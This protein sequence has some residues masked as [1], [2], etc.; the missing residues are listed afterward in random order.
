MVNTD[1]F[2]AKLKVGDII[3]VFISSPAAAT[4]PEITK[5]Y[6]LVMETGAAGQMIDYGTNV[7]GGVTPGKSGNRFF[8][9][10]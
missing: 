7:V 1:T 10:S 5:P 4:N 8:K 6:N 9:N 2:E 3:T